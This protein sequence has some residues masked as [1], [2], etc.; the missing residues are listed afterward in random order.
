MA[1]YMIST[2]LLLLTIIVVSLT[3]GQDLNVAN[4]ECEVKDLVTNKTIYQACIPAPRSVTS[5]PGINITLSPPTATCGTPKETICNSV[6][7]TAIK[8]NI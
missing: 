7:I 8:S 1:S 5:I 2:L 4:Q 3:N 6:S